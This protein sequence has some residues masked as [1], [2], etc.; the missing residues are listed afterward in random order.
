M[1]MWCG[2]LCVF[3]CVCFVYVVFEYLCSYLCV[4]VCVHMCVHGEAR[5]QL[6][7]S[8]LCGGLLVYLLFV[9]FA[10]ICGGVYVCISVCV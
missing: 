9:C 3:A 6:Q 8:F 2:C 1:C 10:C 7:V 4:G 5:G